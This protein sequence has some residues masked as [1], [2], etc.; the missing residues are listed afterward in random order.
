MRDWKLEAVR[1]TGGTPSC[2]ALLP[3]KIKSC[4]PDN[5]H[6]YWICVENR[7]IHPTIWILAL[8]DNDWSKVSQWEWADGLYKGNDD[9]DAKHG[10]LK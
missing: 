3:F 9:V 7:I 4:P 2:L 5:N 8:S 1:K 10:E 6:K